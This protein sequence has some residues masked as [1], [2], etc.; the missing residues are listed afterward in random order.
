MDKVCVYCGNKAVERVGVTLSCGGDKCRKMA[1]E[2]A[3]AGL[4]ILKKGFGGK[5]NV[6]HSRH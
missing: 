5:R 2:H 4:R 6:R 3:E 1:T